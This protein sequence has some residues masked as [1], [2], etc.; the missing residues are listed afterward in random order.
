V[1]PTATTFLFEA[2]NFLLLAALLGW[3]FF[4]PVRSALEARRQALAEESRRAEALGAEAERQLAEAKQK[5]REAE[6]SLASLRARIQ[7]EAELER[8]RTLE[9]GRAQMQ[10]ERAALRLELVALRR[11]QAEAT[12]QDLAASARTLVERVLE[13]IGGPELEAALTRSACSEL[14]RLAAGGSLGDVIVES[15]APL[16]PDAVTAISKAAGIS[17]EALCQQ[18]VPALVAGLRILSSRG[19]VDASIAGLGAG[20]EERLA[21]RLRE[22]AAADA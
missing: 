9:Q 14:S 8:E 2:A 10:R 22:D 12:M 16:A 15:A 11:S 4:R 1:S 18:R 17:A 5:S 7:R 20:V 21:A 19:L 13:R 3:L 6:E